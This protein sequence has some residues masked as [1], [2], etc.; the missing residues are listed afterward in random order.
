MS[1]NNSEMPQITS[2]RS[3]HYCPVNEACVIVCTQEKYVL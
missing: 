1:I 3:L 2:R